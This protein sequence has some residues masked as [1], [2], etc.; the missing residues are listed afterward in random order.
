MLAV[1]INIVIQVSA[2]F[3]MYENSVLYCGK[4]IIL[5]CILIEFGVA[6]EM[7]SKFFI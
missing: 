4:P 7:L 1:S 3:G 5:Y 2:V 6:K